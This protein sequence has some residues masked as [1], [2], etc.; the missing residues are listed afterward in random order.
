MK[1]S[2]AIARGV[3]VLGLAVGGLAVGA[4]CASGPSEDAED[5]QD[6]GIFGTVTDTAGDD[7][8]GASVILIPTTDINTS[9]LDVDTFSPDATDNE[10][11]E[12]LVNDTTKSYQTATTDADGRYSFSTIT[13]DSY[14]IYVKPADT[15]T[16]HLP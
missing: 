15:D 10:P 5:S 14:F 8:A 12:D 6:A 3:L 7:V 13:A 9:R 11:L 1:Y 4:G 16:S 2:S